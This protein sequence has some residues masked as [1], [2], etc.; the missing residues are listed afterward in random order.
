MEEM[1]RENPTQ[2]NILDIMNYC[3]HKISK[4]ILVFKEDEVAH[5][6]VGLFCTFGIFLLFITNMFLTGR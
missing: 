5:G 3:T 4:I 2:Y 1:E 6:R